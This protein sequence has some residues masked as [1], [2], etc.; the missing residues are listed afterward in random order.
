M[1]HNDQPL[2][3]FTEPPFRR[4]ST[5]SL[6]LLVAITMMGNM[7]MH[8]FIPALPATAA[9]LN[10][11]PGTIQ[12]T[13]TLYMVGLAVRQLIYGPLSDRF[14]RR[15]MLLG[16]L[17]LYFLSSLSAVF[18]QSAGE[19]ITARVFQALGGCAGT[20][21]GRAMIRDG[22]SSGEAARMLAILMTA[23]SIAPA[24]APAVGGYV[25]AW[26]GWRADFV[27][28]SVVG[29]TVLMISVLILPETIRQRQPLP[30]IM[31]MLRAYGRL[32]RLRAFRGYALGGCCTST[33]MYAF[34]AASP[35]ILV[36][37]LHRPLQD[38][39]LM[40]LFVAVGFAIGSYTSSRVVRRMGMRRVARSG[41]VVQLIGA[42]SLMLVDV[43]G[44]LSVMTLVGTIM[45]TS[46]GSGFAS[47]SAGAGAIS[48]DP[49]AIGTAS[50]L[51]GSLQMGFGALCA[52][53]V[54]I[55][56]TDSALPVAAVLVGS[57]LL[58]QAAIVYAEKSPRET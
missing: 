2:K 7:A 20:V 19:L 3:I 30:G 6:V 26:A 8:L 40:S 31:P 35:F 44:H 39:G 16:G 37:V 1:L 51:F 47:A 11:S 12:L 27:L 49:K 38:V 28:L 4:H 24:L 56:H 33:S 36:N 10:A 48:A 14:G 32:L 9:D 21:L 43:S 45:L 22:S 13:V 50:G 17:V 23:M 41:S 58:G 53:I 55:W 46:I 25:A 15:P 18:V 54:G 52:A 5:P 57:S 42:L 34:F 29:G